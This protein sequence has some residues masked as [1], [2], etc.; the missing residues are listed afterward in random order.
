MQAV[1]EDVIDIRNLLDAG[2]HLGHQA[3]RWNPKMKPFI[4]GERNGIHIIDLT[5][6]VRLLTEAASFLERTAADGKKILFVCTKK[7]IQSLVKEAAEACQMPYVVERW[8]GGTLTNLQTI[9][10]S[11]KRLEELERMFADGTINN[12]VKQ[13]QS[14]LRRELNK[15]LKNLAGIRH[16]EQLPGALFV[17]DVVRQ[18]TA[19]AEARRL[20]IPVVAI[21][22]TNADP[23]L[24]D[25]PI[26]GNDDAIRSVGLIL[27]VV[28]RAIKR[29][30]GEDQDRTPLSFEQ[31]LSAPQQP[32]EEA[33][34]SKKEVSEP[35]PLVTMPIGEATEKAD[36]AKPVIE[37][38]EEAEAEEKVDRLVKQTPSVPQQ[39]G[40][41]EPQIQPPIQPPFVPPGV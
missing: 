13:E 39:I 29:G 23:D 15:L 17:V 8:L 24:V 40:Q 32:T 38:I 19:I 30:K 4:F 27:S 14:R 31:L 5:K 2:V 18:E 20:K 16:L 7:Q 37:E 26:P 35:E 41:G 3:R 21:V 1:V 34:P 36:Q 25:Y 6:T 11:V 10:R 12:Y 9:R 28:V 22:D 33:P